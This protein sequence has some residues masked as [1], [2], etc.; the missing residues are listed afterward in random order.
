MGK[1]TLSLPSSEGPRYPE[2]PMGSFFG[3]CLYF[4]STY[5]GLQL[6]SFMSKQHSM[7]NLCSYWWNYSRTYDLLRQLILSW[8]CMP[9]SSF[10]FKLGLIKNVF[11]MSKLFWGEYL[12][13]YLSV[14]LFQISTNSKQNKVEIVSFLFQL[15]SR[16]KHFRCSSKPQ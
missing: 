13:A 3:L 9:Y 5:K 2:G 7:R 4:W 15:G 12:L 10:L 1:H 14:C 16:V 11:W 8:A 6:S